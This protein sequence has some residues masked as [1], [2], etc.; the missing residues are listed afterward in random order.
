[1]AAPIPYILL[2][3][4]L[5]APDVRSGD[6]AFL[7]IIGAICGWIYWRIAIGRT[8]PNGHAIETE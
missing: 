2:I 6:G 7:E 1:M 3:G 5:F 4:V 8:P